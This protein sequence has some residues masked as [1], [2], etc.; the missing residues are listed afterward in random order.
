MSCLSANHLL[1][2]QPVPVS[3]SSDMAHESTFCSSRLAYKTLPHTQRNWDLIKVETPVHTVLCFIFVGPCFGASTQTV[4]I[5]S[6]SLSASS[7]PLSCRISP[8]SHF[9]QSP[10][11]GRVAPSVIGLLHCPSDS[12]SRRFPAPCPHCCLVTCCPEAWR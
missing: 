3:C 7:G 1:A 2:P 11:A 4:S 8:Y 6:A 9:H 10:P 12:L 5:Q